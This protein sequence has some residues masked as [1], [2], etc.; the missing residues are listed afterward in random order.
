MRA[1]KALSSNGAPRGSKRA[2]LRNCITVRVMTKQRRV[3]LLAG[4]LLVDLARRKGTP[5]LYFN[6]VAFWNANVSRSKLKPD[7][8]ALLATRATPTKT[9]SCQKPTHFCQLLGITSRTRR[10]GRGFGFGKTPDAPKFFV[11]PG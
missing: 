9:P 8:A 4:S 7:P 1:A 2:N 3:Y 5:L 10:S 6:T 11:A